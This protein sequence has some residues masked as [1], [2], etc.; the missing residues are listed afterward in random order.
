MSGEVLATVRKKALWDFTVGCSQKGPIWR[1]KSVKGTG[2]SVVT[3][4]NL[5]DLHDPWGEPVAPSWVPDPNGPLQT[6][7][8]KMVNKGGLSTVPPTPQRIYRLTHM[9]TYSHPRHR[10]P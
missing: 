7:P 1:T 8:H 10:C 2:G 5:M 3:F 6:L 4:S 9:Y